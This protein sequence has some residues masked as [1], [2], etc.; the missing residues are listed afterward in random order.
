MN[1]PAWSP[2]QRPGVRT[3]PPDREPPRRTRRLRPDDLDN[4]SDPDDDLDWT[5]CIRSDPLM[6]AHQEL[7]RADLSSAEDVTRVLRDLEEQLSDLA[8]R[9]HAV[10]GRL[11]Q[12]RQ[13]I[14]GQYE[15]GTVTARDW[16][17]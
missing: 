13:A 3:L 6:S 12:V 17:G 11:Q 10:E 5:I 15:R 2:D 16:L 1:C 7:A 8:R 14:L 4:L 9:Q